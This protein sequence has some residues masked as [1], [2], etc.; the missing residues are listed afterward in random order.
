MEPDEARQAFPA[1]RMTGQRRRL[2]QMV[3][4]MPGAFTIEELAEKVRAAD[5]S[6]GSVATVYRAVAAM[7]DSGFVTRV[8]SKAGSALY[9]RCGVEGHH[10]HIV[11]DGC[12]RVAAADCPLPK[13]TAAAQGFTITRHEVTLYGLCPDCARSEA[14]CCGGNTEA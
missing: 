13:Q 6:A 4:S 8:G 14:T 3:S 12:G 1:G 11:C 2:V 5:G 9:A 7:E 10:H